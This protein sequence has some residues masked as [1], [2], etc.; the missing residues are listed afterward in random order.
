MS[1]ANVVA[2]VSEKEPLQLQVQQSNMQVKTP[3]PFNKNLPPPAPVKP[4]VPPSAVNKRPPVP[5][6]HVPKL[7]RRLSGDFNSGIHMLSPLLAAGGPVSNRDPS[8]RNSNLYR[9]PSAGL[10]RKPL[11]NLGF[12]PR[13]AYF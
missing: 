1:N 4:P 3:R 8:P 2:Q 12:A 13:P 6:I 7:G 9:V 5:Q 11:G 10:L